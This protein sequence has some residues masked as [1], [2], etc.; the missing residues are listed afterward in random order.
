MFYYPGNK[1]KYNGKEVEIVSITSGGCIEITGGEVV[2]EKEIQPIPLEEKHLEDL[3]FSYSKV[4]DSKS[5]CWTGWW[6]RKGLELGVVC[7]DSSNP[8]RFP[9]YA[10][11]SDKT[12]KL[13]WYHQVQNLMLLI[14]K[15]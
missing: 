2:L 9:V 12:T 8:T 3:G 1:V 5:S 15:L 13:E 6:C 11:V 10:Y 4:D 7:T 14:E